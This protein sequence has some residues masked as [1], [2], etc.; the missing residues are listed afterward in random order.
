MGY[1]YHKQGRVKEAHQLY[2]SN[3]K[4]KLEDAALIAVASN[5]VVCINK[6]QNIFDSKK[7]IKNATNDQLIHKLPSNIRKHIALN[8]AIFVYYTNQ[9][10]QSIKLCN[11]IEQSWPELYAYTK[12]LTALN[13]VKMEKL[14]EAIK[15]LKESANK[16]NNTNTFLKLCCVH[17]HLMQVS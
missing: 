3:L 15:I 7:K 1:V 10:E 13:L 14:N 11:L 16:D 4:I 5:N 17:L 6:D 9:Y 12:A 8:N 2:T